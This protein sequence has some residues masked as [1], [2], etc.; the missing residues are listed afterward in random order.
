LT[1]V[2]ELAGWAAPLAPGVEGTRRGRGVALHESFGS[3]VAQVAEVTIAADNTLQVDRVVCVIDCGF[4]V[5]PNMI[6]QQVEGA[7]VFGLSAALHGEIT[8]TNGRVT[9]G[10]F[11]DYRPLRMSECPTIVVDIIP[12]VEHPEGV[13]EP[14]LPPIAPAVANAIFAATGT[15][16]RSLPL[17]LAQH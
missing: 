17:R 7:V 9:Q 5:N 4:P 13:G 3:V 15:R 6:Q 12:S 2:A 14:P 8:I 10:N 1:R 16:L 11:N